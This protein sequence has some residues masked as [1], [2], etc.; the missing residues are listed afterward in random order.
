[1]NWET[2]DSLGEFVEAKPRGKFLE[3]GDSLGGVELGETGDGLVGILGAGD[4]LARAF[5]KWS[6]RVK[7]LQEGCGLASW[8]KGEE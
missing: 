3:A 2:G 4:G 7:H 1:M 6:G 8:C 5:W